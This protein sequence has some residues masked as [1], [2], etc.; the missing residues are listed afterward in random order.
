[1]LR[2]SWYLADNRWTLSGLR[3][4]ELLHLV[5]ISPQVL[6]NS[7]GRIRVF[8]SATNLWTRV[9]DDQRNH[10]VVRSFLSGKCRWF[11]TRSFQCSGDNEG[12]LVLWWQG[13][14][15]R[16][17]PL[18]R[19]SFHRIRHGEDKTWMVAWMNRGCIVVIHSNFLLRHR[20]GRRN[21]SGIC[22]E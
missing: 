12:D 13:Y 15:H 22:A 2:R 19:S 1:M 6:V 4:T 8:H 14:A 7:G 16:S 3:T 5:Q 21:W 17:T 20:S 9:V 18:S 10:H 11:S